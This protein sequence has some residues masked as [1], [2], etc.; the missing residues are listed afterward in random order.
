MKSVIRWALGDKV[1]GRPTATDLLAFAEEL[2]QDDEEMDCC[3]GD[4]RVSEFKKVGELL[5][6]ASKYV[7]F[8][9]NVVEIT[10]VPFHQETMLLGLKNAD[11]NTVI[12][13]RDIPLEI[14]TPLFNNVDFK[15]VSYA[16]FKDA[17]K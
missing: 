9:D 12:D 15:K 10:N 17:S 8:V 16:E 13:S 5:G 3:A 4:A 2:L 11:R 6:K 14:W 1:C 7:E